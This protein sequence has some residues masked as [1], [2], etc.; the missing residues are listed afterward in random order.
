MRIAAIRVVSYVVILIIMAVMANTMAMSARERTPEYATLKAFGFGPAFLA[1]LIFGESLLIC[2]LG[3]GIGMLLTAPAAG[4]FK[5]VTGIFPVFTV[6]DDT[7]A[8]QLACALAVALAAAV[9]PAVRASRVRIV[10][11]LRAIA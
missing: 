10:E 2:A 3:G 4:M 1:M 7:V 11:G 9:I 5:R 6:S 8:L